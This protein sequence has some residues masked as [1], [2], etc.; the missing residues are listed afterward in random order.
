M[1]V[2]LI[3]SMEDELRTIM[4]LLHSMQAINKVSSFGRF[5]QAREYLKEHRVDLVLL[6]ADD[7]ETGWV[8][9]YRKIKELNEAAKVVLM[10]RNKT[11]A[12]KAY[13][14]GVLDYILKPVK[15]R[16]LERV[17]EKCHS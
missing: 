11:A 2:V 10:S 3:E 16:Q 1:E 12:V 13:E 8:I 15:E 5:A 4:D 17:L 6:D 7:E 9:P 14:A